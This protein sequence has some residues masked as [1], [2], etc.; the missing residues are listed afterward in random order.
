[1]QKKALSLDNPQKKRGSWG[2]K[3]SKFLGRGGGEKKS[4]HSR[5]GEGKKSPWEKRKRGGDA[6]GGV[7]YGGNVKK[8]KQGKEGVGRLMNNSSKRKKRPNILPGQSLKTKRWREGSKTFQPLHPACLCSGGRKEKRK[9]CLPG[10][11][12]GGCA[13]EKTHIKG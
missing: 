3:P 9:G 12:I 2:R 1:V 13:K 5:L 8:K 11:K 6:A 10:P 4:G 7:P